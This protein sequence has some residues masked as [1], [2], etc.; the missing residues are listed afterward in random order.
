MMFNQ[1]YL[2]CPTGSVQKVTIFVL[3]LTSF[4]SFGYPLIVSLIL[5]ILVPM[6]AQES[7]SHVS[8]LLVW[9]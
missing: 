2:H 1:T 3:S 4:V 5:S 8:M 7:L 6:H 9:N